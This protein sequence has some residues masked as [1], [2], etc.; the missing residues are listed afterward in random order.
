MERTLLEVKKLTKTYA[1][2]KF[3]SSE[4]FWA[5][6]GISFCA[7]EGESFSVIGSSGSGKTT[8][9]KIAAG[10]LDFDEGEVKFFGRN[11]S[12]YS[13][14]EFASVTQMIFQN[15]YASLNP[16]LKIK[17]SFL[18][19]FSG[20]KKEE[21]HKAIEE[22]L[23][24]TGLDRAVLDNYPHQFSGGQRQRIAITRALLKKPKLI[25]ADEPFASL[26][27]YSQNMITDIFND[28]R[29]NSGISVMLITH[30]ISLAKRFASRMII[31][32]AGKI[33]ADGVYADIA[34]EKENKYIYDL[35]RAAEF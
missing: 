23:Q 26:D 5:L 27:I 34:N 20:V 12:G 16:K 31:M 8:L 35:V 22:T 28:I 4:K 10:L 15:P 7:K 3:F 1:R 30:D 19:A 14:K 25:I 18:E 21:A 29:K 6:D 33:A 24:K 9:A 32:N 2:E 13:P 11:I 17:S